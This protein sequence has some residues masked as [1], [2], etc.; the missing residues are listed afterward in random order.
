[1][2]EFNKKLI[3]RKFFLDNTYFFIIS[4]ASLSI[5]VWVIQAVNFLDFVTEDGHGLLVYINYTLLNLPKIISRLM[6]FIFFI[7]I[8]YT[9]NKFEDNNELKIFWIFG[10]DKKE[11]FKVVLKYSLIFV[12]IQYFFSLF[13]VPMTQNKARTFIQSSSIDFFPSLINEKKFID[14]VDKLTIYVE[15]KENNFYKKIFLKDNK[16]VGKTKVIYADTGTLVN[17]NEGRFLN[18][19]NGKIIN[20]NED[21]ITIFDFKNTTFDLSKYLTKS[22][23]TFKIQEKK[24]TDI[25]DCF[26]NFHILKDESYF[27]INDCNDGSLG[28]FQRELFKRIFKPFFYLSLGSILCFLL[29]F[30]KENV[31]FKLFR[32]YIFILGIFIIILSE[33]LL[34]LSSTNQFSFNFTIVFPFLLFL[35][36]VLLLLKK[37]NSHK[38]YDTKL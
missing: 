9:I 1:M 23:I 25:L 13:L 28:M 37:F 31:G 19:F 5:I 3:F 38:I 27:H 30:S 2:I 32:F 8:F 15:K 26:I 17:S 20:I 21:K 36:Q 16:E 12:I 11:F 4:L 29:F 18:L 33:L 22:I 24:T 10:T 14:T 7:S 6:P 35:L 34:P